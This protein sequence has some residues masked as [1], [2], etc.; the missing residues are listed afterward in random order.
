MKM[1]KN[2]KKWG[3]RERKIVGHHLDFIGANKKLMM[4]RYSS[5][6]ID[7]I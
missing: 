2:Q 5:R 6:V 7:V 3:E 1:V 4:V